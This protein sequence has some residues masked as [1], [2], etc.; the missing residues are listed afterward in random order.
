MGDLNLDTQYMKQIISNNMT[1]NYNPNLKHYITY[2]ENYE[3][4]D[5][6]LFIN[7]MFK[8]NEIKFD[9]IKQEYSDHYPILL[10]IHI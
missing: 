10:T 8:E 9:I 2:P 7:N 4:L 5:Y 1:I 3:Q 6:F